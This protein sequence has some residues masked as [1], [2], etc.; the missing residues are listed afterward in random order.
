VQAKYIPFASTWLEERRWEDAAASS[1]EPVETKAQIWERV[2]RQREEAAR[3]QAEIDA[4]PG[5]GLKGLRDRLK[6]NF[7]KGGD[8]CP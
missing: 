2:R 1:G 6:Q 7:A 3:E 4:T 8:Q 5:A